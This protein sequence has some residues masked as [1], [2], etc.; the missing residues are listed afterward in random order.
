MKKVTIK[1]ERFLIFVVQDTEYYRYGKRK[2]WKQFKIKSPINACL[3]SVQLYRIN[4]KSLQM[5]L[6]GSQSSD[7]ILRNGMLDS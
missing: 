3:Y 5:Y 4:V 7:L 2:M 1:Q 6:S